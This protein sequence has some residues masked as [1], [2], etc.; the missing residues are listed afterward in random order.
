MF[1]W[2]LFPVVVH[3]DKRHNSNLFSHTYPLFNE[4]KPDFF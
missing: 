3:L 4:R 1:V 2:H